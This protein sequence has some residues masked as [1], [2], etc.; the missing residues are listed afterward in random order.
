MVN[1]ASGISHWRTITRDDVV[2]LFGHDEDSGIADRNG[3]V[4][5]YLVHS[6]YANRGNVI[7][8]HTEPR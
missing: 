1:T 7:R 2:S 6:S 4:F 8:S 5:T 3:H